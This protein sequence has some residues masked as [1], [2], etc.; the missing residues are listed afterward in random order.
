MRELVTEPISLETTRP[1][2][3]PVMLQGW[4]NLTSIHWRYSPTEVQRLLPSGF[5]VD[6]FDDSAWIGLI[7]FEMRR[8]RLPF[9]PHGG[10]SAGRF[11][12]FPETNIRTYIR[13]PIGRRGVWFF[14]LD[15]NRLAPTL[16]ARAGY[17]LPYCTGD[18]SIE[19]SGNGVRYQSSRKWPGPKG[20]SC[21]LTVHIGSPLEVQQ[22]S[23]EAFLSARWALGSTFARRLVWA[24]VEHPEWTLHSASV[25][26]CN[27]SLVTAAG[28]SAP[29][30]EPICLWSPGVEVKI[31]RPKLISSNR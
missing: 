17:G 10:L 3:R 15:I 25:V 23:L 5:T 11:S 4:Y 21:D 16:I 14:S 13:D 26:E 8:I 12:T 27:E 1:V 6:T 20:A 2:G 30:G 18:M 9:G 24:E 29:T 19:T 7:P 22:A 31:G 28:L